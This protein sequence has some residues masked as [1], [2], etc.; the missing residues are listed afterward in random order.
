MG[1]SEPKANTTDVYNRSVN[2]YNQTLTPTNTEQELAPVS[3]ELNS[4]ATKARNQQTADYSNIMGGYQDFTKNLGGPTKFSFQNV[5][6]DRPAEL[7]ESYGYLREAMPGYRDFAQTGGYSPTDI[8]ELR[9]RGVAPIRAAYG[10]TVRELDR[11]R[12]LGGNGGAP[13]YIAAASRAQRDLPGQQADAL[14]TVN[15]GLADAIRQGKMFGLGG[16]TNTGSIMGGLSSQEASRMLQAAMANQAADIQTQGMGE[17]SLQNLRANQLAALSGQTSLYGTTPAM[18]ATFGNQALNA[19]GQRLGAEQNR[20]G[21]G[22]NLIGQQLVAANQQN[23]QPS[24]WDK[25]MGAAGSVLPYVG[26]GSGGGGNG[27]GSNGPG[28]GNNANQNYGTGNG[29]ASNPYG[30]QNGETGWVNGSGYTDAGGNYF[31]YLTPSNNYTG[32]TGTPWADTGWNWDN[33]FNGS[34]NYFDPSA[35]GGNYNLNTTPDYWS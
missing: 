15:A 32:Y 10:N 35:Y 26:G 20:L 12:A 5:K 31:D 19:Y 18:A 27:A 21:M 9:A 16:M 17:Q 6:A 13:N 25:L 34:G 7:G 30:A 2:A 11:A 33:G 1:S 3:Q 22:V 28:F 24:W 23:N 8:Q 29:F 4:A 14:T